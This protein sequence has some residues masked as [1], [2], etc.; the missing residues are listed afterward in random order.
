M[1]TALSAGYKGL[2]G[3]AA[4]ISQGDDFLS[5]VVPMIMASQAY[6]DH[7]VIVIWLMSLNRMGRLAT[8][9]T[10]SI[11]PFLKSSSLRGCT[12]MCRAFL[13]RVRL[14]TRILRTYALGRKFF[15]W[16]RFLA[17]Q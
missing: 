4:K 15:M 2:T 8:K 12:R 1:H 9:R 13:M 17:M 7:G 10:T 11:T 14:T 6:N 5:Q 3:D 16:D